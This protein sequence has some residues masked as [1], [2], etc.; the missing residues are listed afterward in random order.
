MATDDVK[1][2]LE[3]TRTRAEK[4]IAEHFKGT[5]GIEN[6]RCNIQVGME[7]RVHGTGEKY[8][9]VLKKITITETPKPRK[10]GGREAAWNEGR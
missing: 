6:P 5:L 3:I 1:I 8:E 7:L 4:I 9:A 2:T 10:G